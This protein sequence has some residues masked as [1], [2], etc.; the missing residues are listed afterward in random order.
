MWLD[1]K[2]AHGKQRKTINTNVEPTQN[3]PVASFKRTNQARIDELDGVRGIL[4]MW[5][6]ISHIFCWTGFFSLSFQEPLGRIWAE[7]VGAGP[8]VEV[9][10]ILSGFVISYLIHNRN[11]TYSEFMCGR[12]F[13]IYP[14]YLTC[15]LIGFGAT[16]LTPFV[17]ETA[18]WRETFY[19]KAIREISD[20][21]ISAPATHAFWHLTLLNGLVPTRLLRD[22][23][24]TFLAPAWSITLEWQYY[25]IAPFLARF[26]RSGLGIVVITFFAWLGVRYRD[27]WTNPHLAFLPAQLHLFLIGIGS[28]HLYAFACR[29]PRHRPKIFAGFTA[30]LIAVSVLLVPWHKIALL[31][32]AIGFGCIFAGGNDRFTK[33]LRIPRKILLHPLLQWIGKISFP[34]Y[35][36]HWPI[37][38]GFISIL[39]FYF[40]KITS[41]QAL[42]AMLFFG[43]PLILAAAAALH[44]FIERPM[45]AMGKKFNAR[46]R[47][48]TV[49]SVRI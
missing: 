1:L 27:Y 30:I 45:M 20:S 32:W 15:I 9:F 11:Q 7:F 36:V 37:I 29:V 18:P 6:A 44:A 48:A 42:L 39:L 3:R 28:F 41:I 13:R 12:A 8:A 19:F 38:I 35:L 34:L 49:R 10:M 2:L 14:I 24:A 21:E 17:L 31:I 22:A 16:Y 33:L 5:V 46:F 23:T 47:P 25:L 40:P 43:L 4:S 26:I